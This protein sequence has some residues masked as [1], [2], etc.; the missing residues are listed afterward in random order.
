M[1]KPDIIEYYSSAIEKILFFIIIISMKKLIIFASLL[2]LFATAC[3]CFAYEDTALRDY[4]ELKIAQGTYIP[5][6]STQQ[7]STQF[8]DVGS[9]VCFLATTDL[10]IYD[11]NVV[12]SN[13][14]F[15]GYIEKLNEPVVGTNA[16]MV[17]KVTKMKL[18]D[19]V[20][21]PLSGYI[22]TVNDNLIGG[23]LTEPAIYDKIPSY[24]QG[25]HN[26]LGYVPGATRKM[27]D[28]KVIAAGADLMIVL[29]SPL[30][31]THT[32]IN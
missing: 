22:Y 25:E 4:N 21:M 8:V 11:K 13:T 12:P 17:I 10:Y 27:G 31:I 15:W 28:H 3:S 24:R 2:F 26:V 32:V 20:V 16:S 1:K 9:K 30:V 7:I 6:I 14:E 19:G 5:V 29:T 18:S 23:E